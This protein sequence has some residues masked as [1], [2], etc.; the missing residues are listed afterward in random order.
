MYENQVAEY[1]LSKKIRGGVPGQ[2]C[3]LSIQLMAQV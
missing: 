3:W 2:L 1:Y